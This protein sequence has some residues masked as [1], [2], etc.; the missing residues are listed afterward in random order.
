VSGMEQEEALCFL[1]AFL[2]EFP[3]ALEEGASLPVSPLSRKFT[4]EELHGESL[5]LGLRLLA[6]RGASPRLGALLCQAAYSQLLQTD[7]LPYQCPEEPEGDQEEKVSYLYCNL[8]SVFQSEAVQRTFLNKL[9]DVA[10]AWHRNFPKVALCP[11]RNLQC[12]IHAIKNTRRKMEDRHLALAEFNQ[13]FGIQD[14]VDRAYYAVFDGHGGVDAATYASTHLHVVLSKQ[15]MLQSDATTAFKTAFKRTDDMFRN[16]AKRERLR[17]G[18]TGVAVLIQDQELTVAWLGDSQ[19]ILVRDG[20]VVRLMDPHKPEREDEKQRIEDLGG[21]IGKSV[22]THKTTEMYSGEWLRKKHLKVLEWPSQSPDLNPIE[23]LW[24]E[25]KVRVARR[26]P[27]NITALKK[28]CMEEWA[29]IPATVCAN[30]V[31]TYSKRLT[32]VIANKS[33][34]TKY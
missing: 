12:S 2:E 3:A 20:H 6:N 21:S 32:S 11:S 13:L 4:M 7:L 9:I 23:N 25:L 34:V 1:K 30:L 18:S 8:L 19:A 26:Q 28:I 22:P 5:E 10:L 15:E 33:Y 14:D 17:S 16:K 29:K 27:Q 31:K 24:R